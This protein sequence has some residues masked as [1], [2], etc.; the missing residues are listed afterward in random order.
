[1][2]RVKLVIAY[3]V[4]AVWVVTFVLAIIFPPRNPTALLSVQAVMMV[5]VGSLF[6]MRSSRRGGSK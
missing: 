6:A 2:D 1:M 4:S 5:I 3:A